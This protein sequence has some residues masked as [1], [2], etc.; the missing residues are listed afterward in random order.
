M[1]SDIVLL[2]ELPDPVK[3]S[4]AA[5]TGCVAGAMLREGYIAAIR[6]A[7]FET[8]RI[9]Q[10]AS[11]PLDDVAKDPIINAIIEDSKLAPDD[12]EEVAKSVVSVRISGVKPGA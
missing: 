9:L 10:E 7:G 1:I 4:V 3:H 8:V 2:K 12:I 5:Y 6:A 11:F